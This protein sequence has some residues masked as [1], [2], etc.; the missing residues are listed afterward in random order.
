MTAA[1]VATTTTVKATASAVE[2][3]THT[4]TVEA[5]ARLSAR[6]EAMRLAAVAK[7]TERAGTA[8][9]IVMGLCKSMG[10][11]AAA[12][13]AGA[14]CAAESA[15]VIHA[16]VSAAKRSATVRA[17]ATM[18]EIVAID[19]RVAMRDVGIVVVD[20]APVVP[21]VSPVVPTPA[22]SAEVADAKAV[23]E[24]D[25]RLAEVES[26]ERIPTRIDPYR[27]S[28]HDPRIVLRH[29]N[30]FGVHRLNDDGGALGRNGLLRSRL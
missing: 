15:T 3:S 21:V 9:A 16:G 10:R 5:H 19:E 20:H 27:S 11:V 14:A 1:A 6:G 18:A 17:Y 22:K 25:T 26:R 7:A 8:T 2:S 30:H 29:V 24:I 4:S 13:H 23:A 12:V 28:V